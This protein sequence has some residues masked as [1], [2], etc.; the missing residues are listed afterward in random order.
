M[1]IPVGLPGQITQHPLSGIYTGRASDGTTVVNADLA[2]GHILQETFGTGR[3]ATLNGVG[4]SD[5]R[6]FGRP[7]ASNKNPV[8]IVSEQNT[9][10]LDLPRIN[11]QSGVTANLRDGG[12]VKLVRSGYAWIMCVHGTNYT[13][14]T[15]IVPTDAQLY[16]QAWTAGTVTQNNLPVGTT[17]KPFAIVETAND[18]SGASVPGLV[19]CR[20]LPGNGEL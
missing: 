18:L 6:Q 3:T 9:V 14:G 10:A 15:Q 17:A 1:S 4:F 7:S 19:Y 5:G 2:V 16:G 11:N 20:I 8:A 12:I 13:A